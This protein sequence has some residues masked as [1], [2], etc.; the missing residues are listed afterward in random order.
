ME[1]KKKNYYGVL[2]RAQRSN[3][4]TPWINYFGKTTLIVKKEA[5]YFA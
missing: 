2:Q 5:E 1:G 4:I 3:E